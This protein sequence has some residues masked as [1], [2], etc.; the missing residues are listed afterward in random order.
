M[1]TPLIII[2][3]IGL[4]LSTRLEANNEAKYQQSI[5]KIAEEINAISRNINANKQALKTERDKLF[6]A[7]KKLSSL[8]KSI[9]KTEAEIKST[10]DEYSKLT[11]QLN[12]AKVSQ[13]ENKKALVALIESR[14]KN[15]NPDY[16]KQLLNQENP[17][18]VGRLSN[19]H[20]FFSKAIQTKLKETQKQLAEFVELDVKHKSTLEE[21]KKQRQQQKEQY[22]QLEK[23]KS[24]RA[25]SIKKLNDKVLTS[26]EKVEQ[27]QK[28]R[29]RLNALLTQIAKQKEKLKR[30]E[31]EALKRQ[32]ENANNPKADSAPI[33]RPLVKGGFIKQK[34]RLNYPVKGK[35]SREFGSRLAESGMTS[36]GLFIN[37]KRNISVKSIFRGR[38][39]FA[40]F[41]KG[42][43]LL[44]IIDHGDDHIS[45]YGHNEVLIKNVGDV[46]ETNEVIAKTGVTGGLK[47]AGLYF[48]IRNNATPVNPALWCQ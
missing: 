40:E 8:N 21:L 22:N 31:Q 44:L 37:T 29:N 7:E 20:Q 4:F 39:I 27:L 34:G 36:E 13:K 30:L 1:K 33:V 38:V 11:E 19:Y 3:L 26:S 43:G 6:E 15:A 2:L 28:N 9:N 46:V 24:K 48:E 5:N 47:S 25:K 42:Y 16:I 41:L 14:Y 12:I 18:A 32:K 35:H 23:N 10:E 17:Y 45:L